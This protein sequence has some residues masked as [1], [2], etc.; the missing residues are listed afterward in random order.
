[1]STTLLNI[2]PPNSAGFTEILATELFDLIPVALWLEDRSALKRQFDEWRGEN[3]AD[4]GAFLAADPAR[5][6]RAAHATRLLKVNPAALALFAAAGLKDLAGNLGH[7]LREDA[8]PG[9]ADTLLQCWNGQTRF[10]STTCLYALSGKRIAIKL[11]G[12]ILPGHET[13]WS[14]LLIVLEDISSQEETRRELAAANAY[15]HALFEN[16]PSA[17]WLADFGAIKT[18]FNQL[19]G[20]GVT[21]FRAYAAA[22]PETIRACRDAIQLLDIN[23]RA[24][25]LYRAPDKTGL[26]SHLPDILRDNVL[27][28]FADMLADLW[29]GQLRQEREVTHYTLTGEA[30]NL[31]QQFSVMP[32]HEQDWSRAVIAVTDITSRNKAEASFAYLHNHDV[33]TGL[34]NRAFY[35]DL[36]VQLRSKGEFPLS[37]IVFD[38]NGLKEVNDRLGHAAGDALIQRVGDVLD[39]ALDKSSFAV[40]L[41]GDEFVIFIPGAATEAASAIAKIRAG[42]A[43]NNAA[44]E[45]A[46]PLNFSFGHATAACGA[47]LDTA[48]ARA[49]QAMY[50]E[51]RE[52]YRA[53][54]GIDRRRRV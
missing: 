35:D 48:I 25:A 39:E 2:V 29:H 45:Q 24:L 46:P 21:D 34:Y 9:F 20:R 13:D 54:P 44:H 11:T 7:I 33:L 18:L 36:R 26:I 50:E 49:D 15:A 17:L 10:T 27:P 30:L 12:T 1:M 23:Q 32:G 6:K 3:V 42:T 47:E 16:S 41:G 53:T 51:K 5:L 43:R 31:V 22:S 52:Y 38:L 28:Q 40:R 8:F 19:R 4:L 37:V 14:R